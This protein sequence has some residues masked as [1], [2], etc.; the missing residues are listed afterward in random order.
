MYPLCI[1]ILCNH[2]FFYAFF[3]LVQQHCPIRFSILCYLE[4]IISLYLIE[5]VIILAERNNNNS[6]TKQ[7][8]METNMKDE[9]LILIYQL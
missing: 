2:V 8:M 3:A 6:E 5:F 1:N 7:N 4:L 9:F